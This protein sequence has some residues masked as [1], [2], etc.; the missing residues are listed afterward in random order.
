MAELQYL[1]ADVRRGFP[2][3]PVPAG[4][5]LLNYT[6]EL[7]EDFARTIVE[8]Y[9][10][11]L[12]CPGLNGLRDIED[13]IAGHKSSGGRPEAFNPSW[14]FLLRDATGPLAVLLLA[15]TANDTAE[16][17]YLGLAP[18]ARGR[19]FG[20]L[21]VRHALHVVSAGGVAAL[22]LA[23]DANNTPALRLYHRHGLRRV[24]SKLA[25]MRELKP[26]QKPG[27]ELS[28]VHAHASHKTA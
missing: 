4:V 1:Q 10:E 20:D 2:P 26:P 15:R 23:V 19:G 28:D 7:H 6:A 8:S 17:V 13:V 12:D 11:S 14:W 22:A 16:L 24:G 27:P 3:P 9:R 5:E 21:F 25:L 18:E